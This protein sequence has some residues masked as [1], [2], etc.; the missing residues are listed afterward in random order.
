MCEGETDDER[1]QPD[2]YSWMMD[3]IATQTGNMC[4]G[5][6][7]L[8]IMPFPLIGIGKYSARATLCAMRC[9]A[10]R[11]ALENMTMSLSCPGA[12]G[13]SC[14]GKEKHVCTPCTRWVHHS[15]LLGA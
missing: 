4:V 10:M 8:T 1:P 2:E 5:G 13:P 7:G 3:C 6:R 11:L 15:P 12:A 9:S 14:A